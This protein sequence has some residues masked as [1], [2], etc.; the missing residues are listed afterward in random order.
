MR[1]LL[2]LRHAKSA[3]AET[4]ARDFERTLDARGRADAP[5]MGAYMAR[6]ALVPD[7]AIVSAARRTRETWELAAAAFPTAAPVVYDDRLYDAAPDAILKIIRETADTVRKLLLIGHNPGLHEAA[8]L[9]IA[10]GNVDARER[11]HEELPTSGLVAIDF[12]FESWSRLHPQAGR[13]ERFVS[14]RSLTIATD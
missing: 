7:R 4:G 13:L 1:C 9:L 11:L 6:H 14:P 5:T 3:P 8:K 12:A 10:A 2:L